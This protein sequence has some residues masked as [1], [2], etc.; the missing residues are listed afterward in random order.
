MMGILV[1]NRMRRKER[2]ATEN[3]WS[4]CSKL[5]EGKELNLRSGDRRFCEEKEVAPSI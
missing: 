3:Q 2:D 5:A 1:G 4:H